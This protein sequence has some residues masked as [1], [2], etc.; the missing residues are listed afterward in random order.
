[1]GRYEN[2]TWTGDP[3]A[4]TRK[5]R[6]PFVYRAFVPD[7][8]AEAELPLPGNASAAVSEAD[9][10]VSALNDNLPAAKSLEALARQLLRA[11][12]LAS[13]RIEGFELSQKRLVRAGFDTEASRDETAR[14]VLGNI[15][16][17]ERAVALGSSAR[18]IVAADVIELH[19]T[20][21]RA[22]RDARFAG[23]I[24]DRQN[25]VGGS[26][27]SPAGAEFIPPPPEYVPDLMEDLAAFLNRDDLSPTEQAAVAHAQFETIHPFADGNGRVGRCLIHVVF[28]RHGLAPR[29]VPPISLVLATNVDRY[30]KGLTDYR[31]GNLGAWCSLFGDV[32]VTASK[33]AERLYASISALQDRWRKQAGN[34]RRDSAAARIVEELPGN[35]LIDGKTARRIAGTSDESARLAL[36]RLE[37]AGVIEQVSVGRRNRVWE[38]TEVYETVDRFELA[39]ATPGGSAKPARPAPYPPER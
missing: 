29:Y 15:Q 31:S 10:A 22:T 27:V 12:S 2:R 34:P 16:A 7:A 9:R 28:R 26:S 33:E 6:R 35:P 18:P 36:R 25:W 4:Q 1:M 17:M 11:E 3:G 39:L 30:V 32:A 38:A 8:I 21:L 23:W 5:G 14:S 13:S 37:D 19:A 24:R 20:L